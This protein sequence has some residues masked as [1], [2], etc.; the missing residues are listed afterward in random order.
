MKKAAIS[1][2]FITFTAIIF[3]GCGNNTKEVAQKQN[4]KQQQTL[5]RRTESNNAT[6]VSEKSSNKQPSSKEENSNQTDLS[7]EEIRQLTIKADDALT[8]VFSC[9][10]IDMKDTIKKTG[11]EG[12]ALG[13]S[14]N[15]SSRGEAEKDLLRFFDKDNINKFLNNMTLEKNGKLYVLIGQAGMRPDLK[16]A[17]IKVK[18]E[19]A[20][21]Q[22]EYTT[23]YS[24]SDKVTENKTLI[25]E[26]N[27][28]IFKDLWYIN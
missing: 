3:S 27:K 20:E 13:R 8:K 18:K 17:A 1:I 5:T 24:N 11:Q 26:N 2:I 7:E 10:N 14:L 15:Y 16:T 28:W 23:V 6:S 19:E 9:S 22:V 4:N 12:M 25:L 21:L